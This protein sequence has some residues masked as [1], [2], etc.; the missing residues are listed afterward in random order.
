M[1]VA[2]GSPTPDPY[3]GVVGQEQVVTFLAASA[4]QP[5]HAYLLVGPPGAGKVDL[6]M[7]FAANILC[8]R[9]DPGD[10]Q[11]T[12]ER[13]RQRGHADVVVF[14]AEGRPLATADVK[15]VLTEVHA[16]PVEG[17]VKVVVLL[18]A[19]N[20]GEVV[21][22]RLLKTLEEPPDTV[23]FI[24]TAEDVP[25]PLVT[26]A[27]RCVRVD[28]PPL[29]TAEIH[30]ALAGDPALSG[31]DPG[32]LELA[33]AGAH[34]DLRR[35]R[36]LATDEGFAARLAAWADIPG[37]LD[38][39]GAAASR[40]A[41]GLVAMLDDVQGPVD[42]VLARETA[43]ADAEAER[44]GRRRESRSD[45]SARHRRLRRLLRLGELRA[46][47]AVLART[48]RDAATTGA[49]S[50]AVAFGAVTDIDRVTRDLTQRSVR[51]SLQ[52]RALLWR[53]PALPRDIPARIGSGA[54]PG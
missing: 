44:H 9:Q 43:E 50:P 31:I 10:H 33:A 4:T 52:L 6:A 8:S 7:G 13:V 19:D 36:L 37:E 3:A 48:Y 45:E 53:L 35:A 30:A 5:A 2:G 46:G 22:P 23:V 24:L 18:E 29:S 15:S 40:L 54:P 39:T 34:G 38:G 21:V 20:M 42:A 28:V 51:E 47:L 25:P 11:R 49:I 16:S 27:S 14:G 12:C 17:D 32:R 41:Q 26:I 1:G